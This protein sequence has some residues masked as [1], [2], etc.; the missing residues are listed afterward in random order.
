MTFFDWFSLFLVDSLYYQDLFVF[1]N[2][3]DSFLFAVFDLRMVVEKMDEVQSSP[4][5]F[6]FREGR[7]LPDSEVP[8]EQTRKPWYVPQERVLELRNRGPFL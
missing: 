1:P 7:G 6:L 4:E 3:S 5:R 8:E 2:F